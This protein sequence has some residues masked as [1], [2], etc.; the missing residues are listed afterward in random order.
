MTPFPAEC[1]VVPPPS[2]FVD[3]INVAL[4]ERVDPGNA[5]DAT[6]PSEEF[7]FTQMYQ[8]LTTVDCTGEVKPAV[9]AS[10]TTDTTATRWTFELDQNVRYWDGSPVTASDIATRFAAAPPSGSID[11]VVARTV[12]E[13][14]VYFQLAHPDEP[15]IVATQ[16][17]AMKEASPFPLGSGRLEFENVEV[18]GI[19]SRFAHV[20]ER[21]MPHTVVRFIEY[22]ERDLRDV[23]ASSVDL[24]VTSDPLALEYAAQQKR[25]MLRALPWDRTYV[26]LSRSRFDDLMAGRSPAAVE[27]QWRD[28]LA[29]DAVRS[30][31]RASEARGWWQNLDDCKLP[32]TMK[33]DMAST[34]PAPTRH[35]LVVYDQA[36]PVSRDLA[37]RI[38]ALAANGDRVDGGLSGAIPRLGDEL[39]LAARGVGASELSRRLQA[40]SD[41]LYIIGL[42][43]Q[44]IDPCSEATTLLSR[45]PW[46]AGLGDAFHRAMLPLVDTRRHLVVDSLRVGVRIDG[47]GRL[48]MIPSHLREGS[49]P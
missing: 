6:N 36:D 46:M 17:V 23:L 31:A 13:L 2:R 30:S 37:A 48:M 43:R 47:L 8:G 21:S 33:S 5:Y 15:P 26:L 18:D 22:P 4:V 27:D 16:I 29:R 34:D 10:W 11:S 9:A 39:V 42:P 25:F 20:F 32:A 35:G 44:A 19:V 38:V 49:R 40:G 1:T 45:A 14:D 24:L 28:A 3:T 7:V 12:G 41:F